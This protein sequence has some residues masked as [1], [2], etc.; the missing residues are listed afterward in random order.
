MIPVVGRPQMERFPP[1]AS[2]TPGERKMSEDRKWKE[3]K[4]R[5]G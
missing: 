4:D 3:K 2:C 1:T 5:K